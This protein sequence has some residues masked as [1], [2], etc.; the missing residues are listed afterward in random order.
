LNELV[1]TCAL[2]AKRESICERVPIN[3]A[4]AHNSEQCIERGILK[5]DA[6]P[7]KQILRFFS[8]CRDATV[9]T[10]HSTTFIKQTEGKI[11]WPLSNRSISGGDGKQARIA[12]IKPEERRETGSALNQK[13]H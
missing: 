12:R 2:K 10:R 9:A 13:S 7:T 5:L 8:I 6:I 3:Q 11:H 1:R 4:L